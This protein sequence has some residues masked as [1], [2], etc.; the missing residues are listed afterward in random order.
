MYK[1][2]LKKVIIFLIIMIF[3]ILFEVTGVIPYVS[4]RLS[5]TIYV[6]LKYNN[7][8][9]KFKKVEFSPAHDTYY[10]VFIDK[11]GKIYNFF[12]IP[13]ILPV[14]ILYDPINPNS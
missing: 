6:N 14:I 4:T 3:I 1:N 8:N 12:T 9:L 13:K 7:L 11:N 10:G 2:I 5:T